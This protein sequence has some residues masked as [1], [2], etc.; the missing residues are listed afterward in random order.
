MTSNCD[1]CGKVVE[2]GDSFCVHCGTPIS[3][4]QKN[5]F[6]TK[7]DAPVGTPADPAAGNE[8]VPGSSIGLGVGRFLIIAAAIA[9]AEVAMVFLAFYL[10][11]GAM[12]TDVVIV[13]GGAPMIAL[14]LS[15]I[16]HALTGWKIGKIVPQRRKR[17]RGRNRVHEHQRCRRR[18]TDRL[19]DR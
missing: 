18:R 4:S 15:G 1:S 13:V 17:E 2:L 7:Q 6:A 3:L 14:L 10:A 8:R 16:I 11:F 5:P 19:A 9:S 12:L